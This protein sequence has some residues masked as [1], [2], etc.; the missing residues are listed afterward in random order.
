MPVAACF[1]NGVGRGGM[2]TFPQPAQTRS[3]AI[4]GLTASVSRDFYPQ[5]LVHIPAAAS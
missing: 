4:K 3:T 1:S 5:A 2:E